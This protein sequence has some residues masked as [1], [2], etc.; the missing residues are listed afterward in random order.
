MSNTNYYNEVEQERAYLED[1]LNLLIQNIGD[2]PIANTRI[3][4]YGWRKAAKGRTVWR[5]VEEVISQGLESQAQLL[6]F[7]SVHAA[8]SEVGVYDF[9]F[10]YG[11]NKESYVNIKSSVLGG[12]KNKDDISK[13]VGLIDF[14]DKKPNANLYVATFLI[15]FKP[16]MTIGL[17]KCI[18]FPT[19]WIPDI[20]VNPSNNGN[21]QSSMYKN[22]E[23][24]VKRTPSEF[25]SL[26]V[27]ANKV[28]VQKKNAKK[29]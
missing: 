16:N 17:E 29:Q 4:P 6:G 1:K 18:V 26:I 28:A 11:D 24:A 20:Y 25:L 2:I 12:R 21:L 9:R 3:M 15:S 23:Y 22:L 7:D 19:A 27:Q 8:E 10:C 5:I 14:Y 13:A